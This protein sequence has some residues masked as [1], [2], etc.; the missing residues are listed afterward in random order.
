[1]SRP[2]N[3][4][5]IHCSATPNG[6]TFFEG[7]HGLAGFKTPIQRL[8]A[9]HRAR[10]FSRS[11]DFRKRQNPDLT[12]IGYHFV[13]YSSGV[14][15]TGRHLDEVG[16]H[17]QGH[18]TNSIGVCMLGTD[19]FTPAQWANLAKL[20]EGL[21]KSFPNA[22]I[23][24]HRDLSPDRDRDGVVEPG[25]WLKICPGFDVRAWLRAN[26]TPDPKHVIQEAK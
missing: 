12:S 20:L 10:G 16:A 25:E 7:Q 22:R 8:D 4:I 21:Q 18:N 26:K 5:V 24:G 2:I 9:M 13:V 11:P 23:V 6:A 3:L 1:M 17:V 15:V 19:A 14:V